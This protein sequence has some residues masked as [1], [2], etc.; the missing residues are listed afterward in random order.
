MHRVLTDRMLYNQA[1]ACWHRVEELLPND[2]EAKRAVSVIMEKK[3][4]ASSGFDEEGVQTKVHG[5]DQSQA[6]AETAER[7]L[8]HK[9]QAEPENVENYLELAQQYLATDRFGDAEE[10]LAKAY[11]VS[12]GN[13][14]IREKWEDA[15]LRHLRQRISLTKEPTAKAKLQREYYEKDL[16]VCKNRVERY[17]GNLAFK[18]DLGYRYLLTERYHEAIRELQVAKNDPRRRGVTMLALGQCFQKIKQFP[19]AMRHYELA[20]KE[21]P[22]RDGDNKKRALYLAG[23]LALSQ[24]LNDVEAAEKHLNVLASLDFTY[25]D[26]SALLDKVR[27]LRENPDSREK[28]FDEGASDAKAEMPEPSSSSGDE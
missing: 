15:Q 21:I 2:E 18:F 3:V 9:I 27:H 4:R 12:D 13:I 24:H 5:K 23:R 19:L 17:P 20:V 1:I 22:D 8:Q 26:V 10:I 25:K 6:Y 7:K 28:G 14:D 11:E 16:V